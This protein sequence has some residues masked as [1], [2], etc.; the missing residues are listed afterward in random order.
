MRRWIYRWSNTAS[1]THVSPL[2]TTPAGLKRK[3]QSEIIWEILPMNAET[4]RTR[5][6]RGENTQWIGSIAVPVNPNAEVEDFG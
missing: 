1:R 6:E 3:G 4:Q 2:K 5:R